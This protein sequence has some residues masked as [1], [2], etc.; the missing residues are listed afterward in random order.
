MAE[1]RFNDG[2]LE[3]QVAELSDHIATL[4]DFYSSGTL[5]NSSGTWTNT[6]ISKSQSDNYRWVSICLVISSQNRIMSIAT[7]PIKYMY[8]NA[9]TKLEASFDTDGNFT[10]AVQYDAT[11]QKWIYAAK[12]WD[13]VVILTK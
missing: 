7:I 8:S 1:S 4:G 2:D 12:G 13:A 5:A 3:K 9:A 6:G 10:A 11:N